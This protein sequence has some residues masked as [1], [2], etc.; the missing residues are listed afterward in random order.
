MKMRRGTCRVNAFRR[1]RVLADSLGQPVSILRVTPDGKTWTFH[2]VRGS[3]ALTRKRLLHND[4]YH[5]AA[6]EVLS[7]LPTSY[8][9]KAKV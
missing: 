2:I 8:F 4:L 3:H 7:V 9:T 5:K 6:L 1:A